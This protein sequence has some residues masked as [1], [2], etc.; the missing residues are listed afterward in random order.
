MG[1]NHQILKRAKVHGGYCLPDLTTYYKATLLANII[2]IQRIFL[3]PK[4]V[5]LVF[6][7]TNSHNIDTL[8]WGNSSN[9][10]TEIKKDNLFYPSLKYWAKI[11][12]KLLPPI[13]RNSTYTSQDWFLNSS[14]QELR[15]RW[16]EV[17]LSRYCDVVRREGLRSKLDIEKTLGQ[18]MPWFLYLQLQHVISKQK[19]KD[20][21]LKPLTEFEVILKNYSLQNKGM[22]SALYKLLLKDNESK[23]LTYQKAWQKD[24]SR[25][26]DETSWIEIWR[27]T[28]N[29]PHS[30]AVE[31]QKPKIIT[32]WYLTLQTISYMSSTYSPKCWKGCDVL[33]SF[34]H[35]WWQC[36]KIK[37][38]WIEV[39]NRIKQILDL[40]LT[41]DPESLLLELGPNQ[42]KQHH[43]KNTLETMLYAARVSIASMWKDKNTPDI[44]TWFRKLWDQ[45]VL[46]SITDKTGTYMKNNS[47]KTFSA[48]WFPILSYLSEEEY[49]PPSWKDYLKWF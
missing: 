36:T 4:W 24:C 20:V 44:H 16:R 8:L 48:K 7:Q 3:P 26:L 46:E 31:I 18:K 40:D 38:F 10:N 12:H 21:V 11:K 22:I 25:N 15:K 29:K 13:S 33:G 47:S 27:S 9:K 49:I 32:R 41:L 1:R 5:T 43:N 42:I 35:C 28:Q 2:R 34:A 19:I 37:S 30:Y 23:T 39:I 45:Y 14:H 6:D 17:G